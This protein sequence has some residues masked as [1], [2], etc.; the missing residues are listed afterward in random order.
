[1]T[2]ASYELGDQLDATVDAKPTEADLRTIEQGLIA[3]AL[4]S[5]IEARNHRPLAI[6]LRHAERGTVGGLVGTTVWGWLQVEQLWID[7]AFRRRGLGGK[8]LLLAETEA[9]RRGCHHAR[10][11]TFDFQALGFYEKRG[12]EVFGRLNDFPTG[13]VR[14]FVA[15]RLATELRC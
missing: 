11:D 12:Y 4:E 9:T 2:H 10:L 13:H 14:F 6:V 15:K 3:H 8:L 5:G 1:M 7:D